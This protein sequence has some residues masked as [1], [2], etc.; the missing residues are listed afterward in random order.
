MLG[1][2]DRIFYE[3]GKWIL[4]AAIA[5]A[6]F[7]WVFGDSW[8]VRV[9]DCYFETITGLYCPG[10][11]GTRA[12]I[13]LFRGH[14]ASSFIYHPVVPYAAVVY[15]VFM[16]RMFI[17]R[18]HIVL[19]KKKGPGIAESRPEEDKEVTDKGE[20]KDGRV[21][22][23]IYAGIAIT[24]IQWIIKLVLLVKYDIRLI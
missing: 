23:F 24:I 18:H 21:L 11:G 22:V 2:V 12:V 6:I 19:F 13:E 15:A 17:R 20:T 16:I 4:A 8:L 10:C 1:T 9:P 14:I 7:I 3:T 5:A